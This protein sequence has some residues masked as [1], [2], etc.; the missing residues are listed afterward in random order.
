MQ[1][2]PPVPTN[3][4]SG[5]P[6]TMPIEDSSPTNEIPLKKKMP[7][8]SSKDDDTTKLFSKSL[9]NVDLDRG[10]LGRKRLRG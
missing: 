8:D 4:P 2:D 7:T 9:E 3:Q 5:V 10:G 6:S 1:P